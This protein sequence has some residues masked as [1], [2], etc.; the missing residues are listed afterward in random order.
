[1]H[2][3]L[4]PDNILVND[5]DLVRLINFKLT[6]WDYNGGNKEDSPL[7]GQFPC[8]TLYCTSKRIVRQKC[9]GSVFDLWSAGVT[10]YRMFFGKLRFTSAREICKRAYP[11]SSRIPLRALGLLSPM[12]EKHPKKHASIEQV[13]AHAWLKHGHRLATG[14]LLYALLLHEKYRETISL[15]SLLISFFSF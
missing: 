5:K 13:A 4:N 15:S 1:M 7:Q 3:D 11:R 6:I 12:L 9:G 2:R 10:L 14:I 8:I